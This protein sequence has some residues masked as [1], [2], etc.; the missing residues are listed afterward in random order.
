MTLK[1]RADIKERWIKELESGEYKQGAGNL[2]EKGPILLPGG[3]Q[4]GKFCCLGVLCKMA[5]EEGAVEITSTDAHGSVVQYGNE[6]AY[7]PPEVVRWA[8]LSY[9]GERTFEDTSIEEKRGIIEHTG[10]GI[11]D[12]V[13]L[14]LMNDSGEPFSEIAQVIR[15][16]VVGV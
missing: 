2:H 12:L 11:R 1:M 7:L 3:K 15:K 5:E 6:T 16:K 13:S 9:E 8:G 4:P 10:S 14:S